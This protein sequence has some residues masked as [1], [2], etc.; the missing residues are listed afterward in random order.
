MECILEEHGGQRSKTNDVG[1]ATLSQ[2]VTHTRSGYTLPHLVHNKP[3][4]TPTANA[5]KSGGEQKSVLSVTV[6]DERP[7][8][9]TSGR[10]C[11]T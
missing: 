7:L 5:S 3:R 10:K 9:T 1:R 4:G 6:D 8:S 2:D 11:G